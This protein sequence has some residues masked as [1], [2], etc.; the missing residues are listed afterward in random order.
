MGS[1]IG[2]T[3]DYIR[4]NLKLVVWDKAN[5][6]R[7]MHRIYDELEWRGYSL[8]QSRD[9][10]DMVIRSNIHKCCRDL[11]EDVNDLL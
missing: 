3:L 11:K 1:K 10:I 4:D 7:R 2:D 5:E 9:M 8:K 6:D